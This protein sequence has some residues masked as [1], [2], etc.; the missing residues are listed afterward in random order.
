MFNVRGRVCDALLP[1]GYLRRRLRW[2]KEGAFVSCKLDL[3]EGKEGKEVPPEHPGMCHHFK[4][5]GGS[6]PRLPKQARSCRISEA[7]QRRTW[8]VLGWETAEEGQ[9]L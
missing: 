3:S 9:V 8:L 5:E 1:A 2:R 6:Q 4:T 7:K